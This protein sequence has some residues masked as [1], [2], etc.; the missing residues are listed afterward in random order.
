VGYPTYHR[1]PTCGLGHGGACCYLVGR[2]C[3][4]P[5][6]SSS[7]SA[8][9]AAG[10]YG[11]LCVVA[12]VP[13]TSVGRDGAD[14]CFFAYLLYSSNGCA[15]RSLREALPATCACCSCWRR[16]SSGFLNGICRSLPLVVVWRHIFGSAV[17][18]AERAPRAIPPPPA[19]RTFKQTAG[20]FTRK[21][22]ESW[23]NTLLLFGVNGSKRLFTDIICLPLQSSL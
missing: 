1:Y 7:H 15:V 14:G 6:C 16:P 13:C 5:T 19:Y 8:F 4:V 3:T 21:E 12:A 18:K 10:H 9:H 17:A 11:I 2:C 20:Y 23:A 22:E